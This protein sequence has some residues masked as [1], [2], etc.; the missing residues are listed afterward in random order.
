MRA[1]RLSWMAVLMLMASGNARADC[2]PTPGWSLQPLSDA[3]LEAAEWHRKWDEDAA[4]AAAR[5]PE[6]AREWAAFRTR[7]LERDRRRHEERV[8]QMTPQAILQVHGP[9]LAYDA[10]RD[11]AYALREA[12]RTAR[13]GA[14][15]VRRPIHGVAWQ[16]PT[17]AEA[18]RKLAELDAEAATLHPLAYPRPTR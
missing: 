3:A 9:T 15:S 12:I 4:A 10:N 8:E 5:G 7:E 13:G 1:T 14:V 11:A 2:D 6:G 18:E 16:Y 17:T